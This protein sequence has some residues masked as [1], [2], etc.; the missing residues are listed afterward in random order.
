MRLR[1]II[2]IMDSGQ[3]GTP[4]KLKKY[5]AALKRFPEESRKAILISAL[6]LP[7]NYKHLTQLCQPPFPLVEHTTDKDTCTLVS[8]I[9]KL[10][11]SLNTQWLPGIVY[12]FAKLFKKD[13]LAQFEIALTFLCNWAICWFRDYPTPPVEVTDFMARQLPQLDSLVRSF[14]YS[15][16]SLVWPMFLVNFSDVLNKQDWLQLFDY[17]LIHPSR[18]WLLLCCIVALLQSLQ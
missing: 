7:M 2:I 3:L 8:T 17:L 5:L 10:D 15:F 16:S 9:I 14:G 13:L 4:D 12:P 18:P 11:S 1:L 6:Q